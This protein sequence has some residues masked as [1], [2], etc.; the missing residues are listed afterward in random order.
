MPAAEKKA[1]TPAGAQTLARGLT[2]LQLIC[3]SS[4]GLTIQEVAEHLDV[5]RT[6]AARLLAT[7]GQFHLVSRL[8]GRY[9]P[10]AGLAALGAAFDNNLREVSI[11]VLRKLADATLATASLLVAEG[12]EQVAIAVIVPFGVAYH[13]SFREGSR[14]P[15]D[16]GSA[17]LALLA[18]ASPQ[19]NEREAVAEAR[20]RGWVLTHGE[21]EP[22]AYGLAVPV[23]R[24]PPSPPTAIN[25]IS[26]RPD[27][28]EQARPKVTKA[29]REL[30]DLL[31]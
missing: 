3:D 15:I 25:L 21:V 9:Q 29:A 10:G 30:A 1:A 28:L 5:H 8:D 12:E 19:P 18:G 16:R 27:V 20:E 4:G 17:G 6:V 22:N 11:P 14:Y 13:L 23:T 24:T 2:A 26:H 7:L 31:A